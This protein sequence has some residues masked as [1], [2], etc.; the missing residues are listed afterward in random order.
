MADKNATP[1]ASEDIAN[2]D[3]SDR[4][5]AELDKSKKVTVGTAT[6]STAKA[7]PATGK[8]LEED[9]PRPEA[10]RPDPTKLGPAEQ[11]DPETA[12][13]E[14]RN[15]ERARQQ[16]Q[17]DDDGTQTAT[18]DDEPAKQSKREKAALKEARANADLQAQIDAGEIPTPVRYSISLSG[19]A[20]DG[21]IEKVQKAFEAFVK[22]LRKA[23]VTVGGALSGENVDA[24]HP[25]TGILVPGTVVHVNAIDVE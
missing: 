20:D 14:D 11:P 9:A 17:A 3:K 22:A 5:R 16:K 21:D 24:R 23:G 7:S 19:G 2:A 25:Q 8:A 18:P 6:T 12:D 15:E 13:E 4:D 1:V 10:P